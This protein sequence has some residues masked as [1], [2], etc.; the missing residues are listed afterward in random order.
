[1]YMYVHVHCH[2]SNLQLDSI[3]T[4]DS[5][6]NAGESFT[7]VPYTVIP[8]DTTGCGPNAGIYIYRESSLTNFE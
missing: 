4:D 8:I 6:T 2:P 7:T 1:M 3:A 5:D